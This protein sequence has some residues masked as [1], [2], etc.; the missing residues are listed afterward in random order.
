MNG[1]Y[2]GQIK[3]NMSKPVIINGG[4]FM[5]SHCDVMQLES[6]SCL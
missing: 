5:M 4:H 2:G 3:L 6:Q 1:I